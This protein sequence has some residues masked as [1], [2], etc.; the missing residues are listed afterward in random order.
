MTE[1][2]G[3]WAFAEF[4]DVYEMEDDFEQQIEAQFNE[5]IDAELEGELS[6]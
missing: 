5:M 2:Y 6:V 4:G 1:T 3:R